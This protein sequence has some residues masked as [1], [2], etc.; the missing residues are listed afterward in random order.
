MG[1]NQGNQKGTAQDR[2]EHANEVSKGDSKDSK[3]TRRRQ[4]TPR[5]KGGADPGGP[6]GGS[7]EP[8]S[9]QR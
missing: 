1:N 7:S 8:G 5:E 2:R 6:G 4:E 3:D 9:T